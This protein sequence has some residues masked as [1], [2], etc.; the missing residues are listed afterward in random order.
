M[1]REDKIRNQLNK[2]AGKSKLQK[3][4]EAKKATG[5]T[6]SRMNSMRG[7]SRTGG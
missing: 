7:S 3:E 6:A 2:D 4:R 5:G 1:E